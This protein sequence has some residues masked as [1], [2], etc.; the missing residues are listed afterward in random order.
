MKFSLNKLR[1]LIGYD[2]NLTNKQI[3]DAINKIGFEV[4]EVIEPI[5][6]KNLKIGKINSIWK[7]PE[8]D[9]L[10]VCEIVFSDRTRIIQTN[11]A[12]VQEGK[13]YI[14]IVDEGHAG[15][16]KIKP[17]IIKNTLSEG[18]FCS[19]EEV[20][21]TGSLLGKYEGK[22]YSID[23]DIYTNPIEL[24]H[25]N[26]VFINVDILSNRNDANAYNTMACEIAAYYNIKTS[27]L[28]QK[29]AFKDLFT[30][31][32]YIEAPKPMKMLKNANLNTLITFSLKTYPELKTSDQLLLVKHGIKLGSPIE[33]IANFY[34]LIYGVPVQV[35]NKT[36]H[37]SVEK[38][39][40]SDKYGNE[41]LNIVSNNNSIIAGITNDSLITKDA[42]LMIAIADLIDVRNNLK[43]VKKPTHNSSLS[44]KKIAPGLIKILFSRII[45]N[46]ENITVY[47][48]DETPEQKIEL[49]EEMLNRYAHNKFFE[50]K[51]YNHV[52]SQLEK[53]DFEF[54][55][56]AS[57][58]IVTIPQN[59]YDI[60]HF[61]D[62]IEELFRF[63]DYDHFTKVEIDKPVQIVKPL[64]NIKNRM[65]SMNYQEI[66]TYT[67]RSIEG[68]KFNPFE[69][70]NAI[71][72]KTFTSENH[73][74]IRNS[75]LDSLLEVIIYNYKRK[76]VDL[77]LFEEGM[78]NNNQKSLIFSSNT[79]NFN[80]V[81][82]DLAALIGNFELVK[83]EDNEFIHSNVAAKIYQSSKCVGWI[84]KLNPKYDPSKS[85][86]VELLNY[87]QSRLTIEFQNY[88]KEPITSIDITF[89][90]NE[91]ESIKKYLDEINSIAP[92]TEMKI[93]DKF[94]EENITKT[95]LRIFAEQK[96]LDKILAKFN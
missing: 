58:T 35:F 84:A 8:A 77:N 85:I 78:I 76:M 79:K 40:I 68:I 64:N 63:Y 95:T 52:I 22:V 92:S 43:V 4:D 55:K 88:S 32:A 94:R 25:L 41:T 2:H 87:E 93:I 10:N 51:E 48:A 14:A 7:N 47:I 42:I 15:N 34:S 23:A 59:R 86:F 30:N 9:K 27:L 12:S 45:N 16:L 70:D 3:I 61:E 6:I 20:G 74:F 18:M 53:L 75:Q 33:N 90:V 89:K 80:Q 65:A 82:Q 28:S 19:L 67:L 66:L 5:D 50:T 62:L 13:H 96:I 54:N 73:K 38:S 31:K 26:D 37:F 69:F 21:L 29:D 39:I 36:K 46:L 71:E 44:I 49:N 91:N 81:K 72:L 1:E 17:S 24:L 83:W 57:K 60:N 56:K 11:D